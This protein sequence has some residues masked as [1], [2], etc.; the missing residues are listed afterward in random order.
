MW[1]DVAL[2][3]LPGCELTLHNEIGALETGV[4]I[5][6]IEHNPLGDVR[7]PGVLFSPARA[8]I[9]MED[10]RV[11]GHRRVDIQHV[12]VDLV[13]NDDGPGS[14]LSCLPGGCRDG[15]HRMTHVED[16]VSGHDVSGQI[17]EVDHRLAA[18]RLLGRD[19]REVRGRDDGFD[20]GQS[21]GSGYVDRLDRGV[22]VRASE[23]HSH[24]HSGKVIVGPESRPARD[25]VEAVRT[26]R[27]GAD[28]LVSGRCHLIHHRF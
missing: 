13:V 5:A 25:L 23:Y 10:G 27:A 28:S 4:D 9:V 19:L 14:G 12:R 21:L 11:L 15:C 3:D 7:R 18:H 6:P 16:L 26:Y 8:E 24:E 2:V 20:P 22:G 1:L 17:P